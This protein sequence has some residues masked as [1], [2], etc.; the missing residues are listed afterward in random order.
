MSVSPQDEKNN[1]SSTHIAT[2][3]D[4]SDLGAGYH[5]EDRRTIQGIELYEN[6]LLP[7]IKEHKDIF[8]NCNF[9]SI[10]GYATGLRKRESS[11]HP[12]YNKGSNKRSYHRH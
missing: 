2:S 12:E 5:N 10:K 6:E 7:F 1:D 11:Q 8:Q 9:L 4:L 3:R